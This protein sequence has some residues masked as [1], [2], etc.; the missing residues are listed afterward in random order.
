VT[1]SSFSAASHCLYDSDNSLGRPPG[2]RTSPGWIRQG[3]PGWNGLPRGLP[4]SFGD[5]LF[6]ALFFRAFFVLAMSQGNSLCNAN[7]TSGRITAT[8]TA[9]SAAFIFLSLS[10][11]RVS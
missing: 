9:T 1:P 11:R 3:F 6:C 5:A 2:L 8:I 10:R 4:L 7:S